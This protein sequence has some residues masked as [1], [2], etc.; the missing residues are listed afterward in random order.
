V[1]NRCFSN[2]IQIDTQLKFIQPEIEGNTLYLK[3]G[4][5]ISVGGR[6]RRK[7][8]AGGISRADMTVCHFLLTKV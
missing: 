7:K 3:L 8:E 4:G 5:T 2:G 6:K 1:R